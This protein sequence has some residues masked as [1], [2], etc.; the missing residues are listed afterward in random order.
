MLTEADIRLE[1]NEA[2]QNKG[3]ILLGNKKNVFTEYR[4]ASGWADYALKPE[5]RKNPLVII[6]AKRKGKNLNEALKQAQRYAEESKAPIAYASDGST[7]KTLHLSNLKPLI[8]NGEEIDEFVSENLALKF[9]NTN[10][11]NT[12]DKQVIKSRK[13]LINIFDFANKELRKEGLQAGIERFSEFCNI[14][15]LKIFSEDEDTRQKKGEELRIPKEFNW[16]YFKNKDGNELL[17]Y[18]NDSVL[19][20]FQNEYGTDIFSPLQIK[21]PLT[22]KRIIDNL[23]PLSLVDTNSDVKGDAFE[24]FLKA[25]LSNQNKD[26]GEYFTPR[27]IVKTLVKLVNPRLGEK[28]YD[29]FCGTG[30]ILI[31]A[32]RHIYNKMPRNENTLR[33]LKQESIYGSEITKN[34]RITKMNMILTGDGHNNIIQQDSLKN[35]SKKKYDIVLTNMPF[36]LG[37]YDEY[38]GLYKLGSSNGNSLCIEHC[39]NAID[40]N[41]SN[42]RIAIIVPEG[43]LFDKKF[44]KLREYIYKNSYVKNIISLPSGA[45]KPYTDV[46]TSI[47]YLTKVNQKNKNQKSVW[48]YTVKNDGYTLNTKRQ[49]K[50]GENDLDLFLSFNDVEEKDN[51]LPIGFN[52]LDIEEIKN[53]DYISIAN[54]YKKFEFNS[55]FENILLGHLIEECKLRNDKNAKVWSITNKNGGS[56]IWQEEQFNERVA[57]DSTQNYKIVLPNF[58][59]YSPPRINVGSIA[60]NASTDIGCV[61]PMYVVFKISSEIRLNP[62]YLYWL[63]QGEQ[64][65]NQIKNFSFG[66]VRQT[67]NFQ[68]FCKIFIPLPPI[69]EQE[70]IV[71]ELDRYQR[72][73]DG[74]QQVMENWKPYFEIDESYKKKIIDDVCIL[75]QRGKTPIYGNSSM[76][77]IKSGQARG[78]FEF[79]FSV[80]YYVSEDFKVDH[81]K[82]KDGDIL[83]NSTGIGTAGRVT[84]FDLKGDFLVDSHITILRIKQEIIL[85]KYLLYYLSCVY[86]FKTIENMARGSSGKV[87][88]TLDIIKN[89]QI[90]VPSLPIQEEI[91]NQLEAERKMIE[92]QKEIIKTFEEKIKNRLNTLWRSEK[93][94]E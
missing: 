67:L 87:E 21:N 31:E 30:G 28:V 59:A 51:L 84:Y 53:N 34:A 5:S 82:L 14:L 47:L 12:L 85:P 2:L 3:W 64:F 16:D 52:K 68:D 6:E 77:I 83:I 89:I 40:P 39:F 11:Y 4:C 75:V 29:P 58:F 26:L 45:F 93:E 33:Q 65:K 20:C 44:K 23:D 17:S 13:E 69:E 63:F 24:Y 48:Y 15:F 94:N 86:G 36:S 91:V 32:F 42:P 10:E 37:R 38:S 92:S 61:S 90:S 88:L 72:I 71:E 18:V 54:P 27:H 22:L 9:L 7:I 46:K 56:F 1:I 49:K 73:I 78:L 70:K 19:R 8:L 81:R 25:Y 55:K 79:D 66:S 41:G 43:I 62:K 35:P 60:F 50:E 80:K 74:A 76:Q 57:S